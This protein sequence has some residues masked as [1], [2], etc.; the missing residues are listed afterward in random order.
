MASWTSRCLFQ[1]HAACRTGTKLRTEEQGEDEQK[2]ERTIPRKEAPQSVPGGD[3]QHSSEVSKLRRQTPSH[4]NIGLGQSK[5]RDGEQHVLQRQSF[6]PSKVLRAAAAL[7]YQTLRGSSDSVEHEDSLWAHD[8]DDD[9]GHPDV[10]PRSVAGVVLHSTHSK[11]SSVVL[12]GL[13][14]RVATKGGS[15]HRALPQAVLE[16]QLDRIQAVALDM[17]ALNQSCNV[18]SNTPPGRRRG[19]SDLQPA[20]EPKAAPQASETKEEI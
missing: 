17:S 19:L 11:D 8:V 4:A 3:E 10:S 7:R 12:S 6:G 16:Q 5:E 18:V 14:T 1:V 20:V 9:G 2:W 13:W 15:C